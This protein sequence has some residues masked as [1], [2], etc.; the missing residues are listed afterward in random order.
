MIEEEIKENKTSVP[1]KKHFEKN[2]VLEVIPLKI[3]SFLIIVMV[4]MKI[5]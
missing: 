3:K 5:K 1:F 2:Q 4:K